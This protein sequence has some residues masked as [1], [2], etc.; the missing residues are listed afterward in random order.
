M[1]HVEETAEVAVSADR[2]W[3][4]IGSFQGVGEWHPMLAEV[5]GDGEQPGA[6]RTAVGEDGSEQVERLQE[7]DPADRRYRYTMES[8]AMP[9]RD[10]RAE[11]EVQANGDAAS[12]VR[13]TADFET[14]AADRDDTV[15]MV[16]GFL[17][18]GV[19]SLQERYAGDDLA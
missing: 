11:L 16:R 10:Y 18:A 6:I 8:S 7:V 12:S 5:A 15:R 17:A 3:H 4:A 2:L 9:V 1:P 19:R 14:T 13:W